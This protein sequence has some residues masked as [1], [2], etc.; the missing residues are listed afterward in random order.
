V[1]SVWITGSNFITYIARNVKNS[2]YLKEL[3]RYSD[4]LNVLKRKLIVLII[5]RKLVILQLQK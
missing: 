1:L 5:K 4:E 3:N 2:I